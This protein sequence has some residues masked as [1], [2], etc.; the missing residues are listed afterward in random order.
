MLL[1]PAKTLQISCHEVRAQ[2]LVELIIPVGDPLRC[3]CRCVH[4]EI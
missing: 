1:I 3:N 2:S 4:N